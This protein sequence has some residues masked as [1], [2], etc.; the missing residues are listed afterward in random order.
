MILCIEA[1]RRY[2]GADHRDN[3]ADYEMS[4]DPIEACEHVRRF[5]RCGYWVEV[6]DD[7][8]KELLAG[9]FD[10]DRPVPGYIV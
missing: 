3:L 10:P 6:Y 9:P 2:P 4:A 5:H 8:T 7:N 1:S